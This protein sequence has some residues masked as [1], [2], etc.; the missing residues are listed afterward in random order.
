[1]QPPPR[2]ELV[3]FQWRG[4]VCPADWPSHQ[5]LAPFGV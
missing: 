4:G 5:P 1:M 2:L 3:R